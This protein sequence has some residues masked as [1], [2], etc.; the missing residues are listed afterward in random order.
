MI[1]NYPIRWKKYIRHAGGIML[2]CSVLLFAKQSCCSEV[3]VSVA[4]SFQEAFDDLVVSYEQK[5]KGSKIVFN[6]GSSQVL[7]KQIAAGAPVDMFISAHQQWT[8][9]LKI[10]GHIDDLFLSTLA[11]NT[12][13]V[14]GSP[15]RNAQSIQDLR[16]MKRI[17]IGNPIT[18]AHGLYTLEAIKNAGLENELKSRLFFGENSENLHR[19]EK[20]EV[21]GAIIYRTEAG[22]LQKMKI[23]FTIPPALH[24]PITYQLALTANS[25]HSQAA[26]NFYKFLK[27]AEAKPILLRHGYSTK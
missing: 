17:A 2:L 20:G 15:T 6:Y 27:S 9:Y 22:H 26:L 23:L 10:G 24:S 5:S 12:L 7:A 19:I 3:R 13:V 16:S 11:T 4:R 8:D 14:I 21:D 18:T 1:F 25:T